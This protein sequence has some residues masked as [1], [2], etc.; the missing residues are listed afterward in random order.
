[1]AY[2]YLLT[3]GE[4]YKIGVTR[5]SIKKRID[6]LQT[7]N[8]YQI[9]VIHTYETEYPFKIES[10]L[11]NQHQAKKV[12]NEWFNLSKDDI[13]SFIPDCIKYERII[14]SLKGNPFFKES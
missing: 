10:M 5:G 2:V 13:E 7:G 6:K 9:A 1:M 11:H 4:L 12:N 14:E 8:P 3:D